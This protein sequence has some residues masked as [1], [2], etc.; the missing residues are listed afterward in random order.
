ML[1]Y[2]I[3]PVTLTSSI[4]CF[5][6]GLKTVKQIFENDVLPNSANFDTTASRQKIYSVFFF[7]CGLVLGWNVWKPIR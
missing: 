6:I 5:Q 1:E 4:T 2:L 7:T 3:G